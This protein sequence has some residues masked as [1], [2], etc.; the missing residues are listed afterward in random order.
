MGN[1]SDSSLL[2]LSTIQEFSIYG[3]SW[4]EDRWCSKDHLALASEMEEGNLVRWLLSRKIGANYG[5]FEGIE[6]WSNC[7]SFW[8]NHSSL[9]EAGYNWLDFFEMSSNLVIA[10]LVW[11][12]FGKTVSKT[13]ALLCFWERED[14]TFTSLWSCQFPDFIIGEL[15]RKKLHWTEIVSHILVVSVIKRSIGDLENMI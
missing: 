6:E 5:I 1:R 2:V 15:E 8:R 7:D 13:L 4:I 10:W 11:Y 9:S 3:R 12:G 14:P